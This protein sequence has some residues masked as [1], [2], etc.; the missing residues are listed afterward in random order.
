MN[1]PRNDPEARIRA[2]ALE[3]RETIDNDPAIDF[4]DLLQDLRWRYWQYQ[5]KYGRSP[6]W[7]LIRNWAR[8]AMRDYGYVG[9]NNLIYDPNREEALRY[10]PRT[11]RVGDFYYVRDQSI[12]ITD[13]EMLDFMKYHRTDGVQSKWI[14]KE[15]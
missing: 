6:S 7:V 14:P 2:I 12:D 5:Q 4:D 13:E 3:W 11:I 9:S 1:K 8:K 15:D 10:E